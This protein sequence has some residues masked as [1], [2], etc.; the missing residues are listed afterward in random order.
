MEVSS[1]FEMPTNS[2]IIAQSQALGDHG[3]GVG[4]VGAQ[5]KDYASY[6]LQTGFK[7]EFFPLF[8]KLGRVHLLPTEQTALANKTMSQ[9]ASTVSG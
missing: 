4:R 2:L 9:E 7:G 3:A 8:S 6:M 1:R 5:R